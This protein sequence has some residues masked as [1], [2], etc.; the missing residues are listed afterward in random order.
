MKNRCCP[1]H[2]FKPD[3]EGKDRCLLCFVTWVEWVRGVSLGGSARPRRQ[4]LPPR[5][6]RNER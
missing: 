5:S 3:A 4:G 2:I 6:A 1:P